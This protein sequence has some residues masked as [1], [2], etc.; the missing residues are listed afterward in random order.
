MSNTLIQLA[1]L[2]VADFSH[3][4]PLREYWPEQE[5]PTYDMDKL[6]TAL[7]FAER[8]RL[9]S[10]LRL[11]N[12][13]HMRAHKTGLLPAHTLNHGINPVTLLDSRKIMF[14]VVPLARAIE[15][16]RKLKA[17]ADVCVVQT[18]QLRTCL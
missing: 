8:A 14:D 10:N 11:I 17:K 2:Q 6:K 4:K 16:G 12:E 5:E 13:L 1:D 18:S 7:P 3:F 15:S 9:A